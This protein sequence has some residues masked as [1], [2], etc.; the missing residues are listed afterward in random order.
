M[1]ERNNMLTRLRSDGT[2]CRLD[3]GRTKNMPTQLWS[4]RKYADSLWSDRKYADSTMIGWNN[5]PSRLRSDKKKLTWLWSDGTICND[6]NFS[7]HC[8][9][10]LLNF[11]NN[12]NERRIEARNH[13]KRYANSH[14][15][16]CQVILNLGVEGQCW[17][18][19]ICSSRFEIS[20]LLHI[21]I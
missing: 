15:P 6:Y 14:H 13:G 16:M 12:R 20:S 7:C 2:I 5:M 3:Y 1:I 10:G 19:W 8:R 18:I 17:D 21:Y 9:F 11:D 4:D